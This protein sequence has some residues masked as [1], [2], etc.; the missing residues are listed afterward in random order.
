MFVVRGA[1]WPPELGA[2]PRRDRELPQRQVE[3]MSG[4]FAGGGIMCIDEFERP[5]LSLLDIWLTR[6]PRR[7]EKADKFR[8]EV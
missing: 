4:A 2:A 8:R 1:P 7:V 6:A 3:G 5:R